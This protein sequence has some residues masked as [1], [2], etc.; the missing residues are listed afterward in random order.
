MQTKEELKKELDDFNN[1]IQQANQEIS[2]WREQALR[3]AGK[4]DLLEEQEKAK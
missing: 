3:I 1:K 4:I 2:G